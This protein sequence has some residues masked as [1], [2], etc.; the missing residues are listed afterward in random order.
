MQ[1]V[2]HDR[3]NP[4]I[5]YGV[6]DLVDSSKYRARRINRSRIQKAKS[7]YKAILSK[8]AHGNPASTYE[9]QCVVD[10]FGSEASL[11]SYRGAIRNIR[12]Q[13][14][15]KDR[16]RDGIIRSGAY[17]E[18]IREVF[19]SHRL[20]EDLVYLPHVESS[21]NLE[22]YSKFG[23]AGI[24]QFTRPT[25]RRFLTISYTLDERM[26]PI[27]SSR[28]AALLLKSNYEKLNS[29][30]MAITAYNH[31]ISGMLRAK[32]RK[33]SYE[34]IFQE[35]KSR[36]FG[37]ASRNFYAE[38]LAA[39]EV[40]IQYQKYF[41]DLMLDSAP[42]VQ[43]VVLPGY[44]SLKKLAEY[45]GTDMDTLRDLNPSL[46]KPVHLGQKHVPKGYAFLVPVEFGRCPIDV[47][48]EL[49]EDMFQTQQKPSRFYKVRRGD[50]ASMIASIHGIR[51]RDLILANNL[52]SRATIFAGETLRLPQGRVR[53][54]TS[55]RADLTQP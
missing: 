28:A 34:R 46:R 24:W 22:A 11:K 18:R 7:K 54:D 38:F 50:T 8:L 25:G 5:V 6:I 12:C 17:L 20:P 41:G 23:A 4:S 37:F 42:A 40:A 45:F 44:A 43:E 10:L 16:F 36:R 55:T 19:N 47:D 27:R 48:S 35:Y 13:V 33:G 49:P 21:F 1:G 52:N 30:P 3:A 15:Q 32:R 51:L 29:W 53:E 14:G 9:E 31:G 26:D 2:V 39:R